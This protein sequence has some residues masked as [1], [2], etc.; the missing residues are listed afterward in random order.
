MADTAVTIISALSSALGALTPGQLRMLGSHLSSAQEMQAMM[1]LTNMRSS[2]AS[3]PM[4]LTS[5]AVIPNIP[6]QVMTWATAAASNPAA[7]DFSSNIN[8]A[9]AALQSQTTSPN[10]LGGLFSGL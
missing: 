2:P 1:V 6:A 4:L 10:I 3:A 5:L 8:Q 9:I 7:P